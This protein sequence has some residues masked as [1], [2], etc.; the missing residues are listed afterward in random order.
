MQLL[1]SCLC[2]YWSLRNGE[3]T[4][5]Q[6]STVKGSSRSVVI[7]SGTQVA[8]TSQ[9]QGQSLHVSPHI[10]MIISPKLYHFSIKFNHICRVF[11]FC[12]ALQVYY[13]VLKS[14]SERRSANQRFFKN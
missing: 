9:T 10:S 8:I 2:H 11:K 4:S 6:G 13:N 3:A 7:R 14:K 1:P 12:A 5:L